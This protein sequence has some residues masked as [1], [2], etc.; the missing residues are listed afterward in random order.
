MSMS[1][2][3]KQDYYTNYLGEKG[4]DLNEHLEISHLEGKIDI[5]PEPFNDFI[6]E[7]RDEALTKWYAPRPFYNFDSMRE[8]VFLNNM[9]YNEHNTFE[10]NW[11]IN[12]KHNRILKD[13]I[14]DANF[15]RMTLDRETAGVRLL[16]YYPGHGIPLHTDSFNSFRATNGLKEGE[17]DIMRYFVAVSP[18]DWGHFLQVHD[19]M[20]HHW[21]PGYTLQIPD[22]VFHT[23]A[24]FGIQ[25]KITLTVT[26]I[27]TE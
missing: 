9:G 23:S 22:G 13:L 2:Y 14:G 5:D 20:I 26:G 7:F 21:E 1:I 12:Q 8:A 24:N 11:G 19:N 10:Y 25:P 3:T 17:G 15:D 6:D 27:R 4:V 16:V 18:W